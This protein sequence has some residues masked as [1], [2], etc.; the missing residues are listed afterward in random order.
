MKTEL[1]EASRL[2]IEAEA[3]LKQAEA[4][5]AAAMVEARELVERA[6]AEAKRV[7][8]AAACR[9]ARARRSGASAWRW[10]ASPR[11]KPGQ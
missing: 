4:D 1:E 2:R 9:S 7:A 10:T 6:Q 11:P 3:L 5:R 8:E